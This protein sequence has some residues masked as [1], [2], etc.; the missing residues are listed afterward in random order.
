MLIGQVDNVANISLATDWKPAVLKLRTLVALVS[1]LIALVVAILVL[2]KLAN[3]AAL[4][5]RFFTYQANLAIFGRLGVFTPFSIVPTT[6]A[7]ALSLWWEALD[8]SVRRLQPFLALARRASPTSQ[9]ASTS[10]ISTYWL[11]ASF[12]AMA[13]RHWILALV[14]LGSFLTQ[15]C[16]WPI[17]GNIALF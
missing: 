17:A 13:H 11:W 12:K 14:T 9:E 5:Q 6:L 4:Y 16:K 10:Y 2:Y 1:Y 15:V 3:N 7:I 8:K